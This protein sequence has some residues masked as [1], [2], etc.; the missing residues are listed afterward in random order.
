M[1][2]GQSDLVIRIYKLMTIK[3]NDK[4]ESIFYAVLYHNIT[5]YY[6]SPKT[7]PD[8]LL[9]NETIIDIDKLNWQKITDLH[10]QNFGSITWL[11]MTYDQFYRF[12][13][14]INIAL[15]YWKPYKY[16][17]IIKVINQAIK[18]GLDYVESKQTKEIKEFYK[19]INQVKKEVKLALG[20]I[21]FIPF[22]KDS[23][24][25]LVAYYAE[26]NQVS[27]LVIN[28]LKS[29]YSGYQLLIKTPKKV[30]L[31]YQNKIF[32][33]LNDKFKQELTKNNLDKFW[34]DFYQ[35]VFQPQIQNSR[36]V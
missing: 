3:F 9:K 8:N 26:E 21:H 17:I 22:I 24:K 30:Y 18:F 19:I 15:R 31:N 6:L 16:K 33:F 20:Y 25:F 29:K 2:G 35:T 1:V 13:K 7:E 36:L 23:E 14:N 5:G 11:G 34:E 10:N 12:R 27:D 32:C 4:F 28:K